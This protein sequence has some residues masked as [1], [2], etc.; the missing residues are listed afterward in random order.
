MNAPKETVLLTACIKPTS[1]LFLKI[2]NVEE[3]LVSYLKALHFWIHESTASNIIF[4]ENSLYEYDYGP[5]IKAASSKGKSLEILQ[6]KASK[7][8]EE[9]GKGFSEGE[10][11]E[12]VINNSELLKGADNFYKVT[13]RLI[14]S[15]FNKISQNHQSTE[16]L[17]NLAAPRAVMADTRFFKVKKSFFETHLSQIY[18]NVRDG[19]GKYLEHVFY[20]A[21]KGKKIPSFKIYPQ[22]LGSSGSTGQDTG[23]TKLA[24][25]LRNIL[26]KLSFYKI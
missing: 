1:T 16:T 2:T 6:F 4:A 11:M 13:G 22:I 17:F 10:I 14:V 18:K 7:L 3:R 8:G 21:L 25:L 9:Y 19:E 5:L 15:N 26:S 23:K 24:I 12:Y 20:D